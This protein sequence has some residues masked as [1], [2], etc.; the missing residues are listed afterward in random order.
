[1][2]HHSLVRFVLP[3]ALSLACSKSASEKFNETFCGYI[4]PCCK[5]LGIQ[6]TGDMSC[7]ELMNLLSM[8][9]KYDSAKGDACLAKMKAEVAAGTFCNGGTGD[10]PSVCNEVYSSDQKRGNK[11]AGEVCDFDN[12]C[13]LPA[14]GEVR[15]AADFSV[16]PIVSKCQV[17]VAGALGSSPCAGT[18]DGEMFT[19]SSGDAFQSSITVCHT[20]DGVKCDST[21][22]TCVALAATG[23]RCSYTS[24]CVRTDYCT[25]GTSSVCATKLGAGATCV[26]ADDAPCGKDLYCAAS[27]KTCVA[28]LPNGSACS[29]SDM[30]QS[31]YCSTTCQANPLATAFGLALFCGG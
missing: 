11:K 17:R 19:G 18:Q 10:T 7:T 23:S 26:V 25:S 20:A 14:Q 13:A 12:D 22:S 4:A 31:G 9:A 27:S 2:K 28:T 8:G 1:M 24:D 6:P 15:C 30:C 16:D 3:L 5:Q 21:K 29:D